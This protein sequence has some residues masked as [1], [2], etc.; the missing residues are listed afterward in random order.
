MAQHFIENGV[1]K[2]D[3]IGV[4]LN[5]CL[6]TAIA[7]YGIMRAGGVYVPLDTTGPTGRTC[8]LLKD[9]GI[10]FV[11]SNNAQKRNL[12][13]IVDEKINLERHHRPISGMAHADY[14][15]GNNFFKKTKFSAHPLY[16]KMTPPI[17]FT[18]LASTGTPKGIMHTHRSG[19]A[20]AKL[21]ADL[22]QLDEM[23]SDRKPCAAAFRHIN[24][25]FFLFAFG[26]CNGGHCTRGLHQIASEPINIDGKRK[27][28]SMVF[29]AIG[30][31]ADFT[32]GS[33]RKKGFV[34]AKMGAFWG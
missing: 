28:D 17:S 21:A 22:Y 1:K 31:G 15:L 29:R 8:F 9:C 25:R 33:H 10:R 6:D 2:G 27:A 13:K 20:Y 11:V 4:Y 3:R 19:L 18:P 34:F 5:R 16:W 32:A 26:G 30:F 12:Q 24:T 14:F 7:T 23:D